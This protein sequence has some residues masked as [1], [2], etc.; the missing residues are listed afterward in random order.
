M[1]K[2]TFRRTVVR[3]SEVSVETIKVSE[4]AYVY[5]MTSS[6]TETGKRAPVIVEQQGVTNKRGLT[7]VRSGKT[8]SGQKSFFV[9]DDEMLTAIRRFGAQ[10]L[11]STRYKA[12]DD[13]KVYDHLE[14]GGSA[15]SL[16]HF[17]GDHSFWKVDGT[18]APFGIHFDYINARMKNGVY[19]LEKVR[20]HLWGRDDIV[21]VDPDPLRG[22]LPKVIEDKKEA[23]LSVPYYN[24]GSGCS[25]YLNFFWTPSEDILTRLYADDKAYLNR[26][27]TIF[28]EDLLGLRKAGAAKYGQF[29]KNDPEEPRDDYDD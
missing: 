20:D 5:K 24:S 8:P 25:Q 27:Q 11:H 2:Q 7:A 4:N 18:I 29:F 1:E 16:L 28:D 10:A 26:F 15:D 6:A 22:H 3:T 21:F 12:C 9:V 13:R 23:V 14:A 17:A 19:D